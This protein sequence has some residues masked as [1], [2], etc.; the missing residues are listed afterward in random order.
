MTLIIAHVAERR[1]AWPSV[2]SVTAQDGDLT[3]FYR[4]TREGSSR[5]PENNGSG[6]PLMRTRLLT[7]ERTFAGC[8]GRDAED[9]TVKARFLNKR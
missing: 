3:L 6:I 2:L 5:S 1:S 7:R 9:A 8:R 4:Y